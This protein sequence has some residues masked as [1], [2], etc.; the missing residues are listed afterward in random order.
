M[1]DYRREEMGI[2]QVVEIFSEWIIPFLMKKFNKNIS[3]QQ[4]L[5]QKNCK[6]LMNHML[7]IVQTEEAMK[8]ILSGKPVYAEDHAQIVSAEKKY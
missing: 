2:F 5:P 1:F 7:T 4:S 8:M 3:C 6:L